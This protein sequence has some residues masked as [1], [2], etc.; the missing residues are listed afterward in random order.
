MTQILSFCLITFIQFLDENVNKLYM[1]TMLF[2]MHVFVLFLRRRRHHHL[3]LPLLFILST[4]WQIGI[5]NIII[6]AAAAHEYKHCINK[7]VLVQYRE[8]SSKNSQE[9]SRCVELDYNI[10]HFINRFMLKKI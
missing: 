7:H 3:P 5:S 8:N 2:R 6:A 1:Y 9:L 10:I 4:V